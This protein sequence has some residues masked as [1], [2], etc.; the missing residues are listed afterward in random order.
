MKDVAWLSTPTAETAEHTS[1]CH[2]NMSPPA[3]RPFRIMR[4]SFRQRS[5]V[6]LASS[7]C[8]NRWTPF[9]NALKLTCFRVFVEV[10]AVEMHSITYGMLRPVRTGL[11]DSTATGYCG[12][13]NVE[14]ES[15][16]DLASTSPTTRGSPPQAF[17][18]MNM[19]GLTSRVATDVPL[20]LCVEAKSM[21]PW[22]PHT[23]SLSAFPDHACIALEAQSA[24]ERFRVSVHRLIPFRRDEHLRGLQNSPFETFCKA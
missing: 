18:F 8:L 19:A 10:C 21:V 12:S 5:G 17:G 15:G 24:F 23:V 14:C 22:T 4:V 3:Y 7:D 13:A 20:Y 2:V 1:L 9:S 16:W 6:C 11:G